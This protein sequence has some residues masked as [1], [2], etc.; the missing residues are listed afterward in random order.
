MQFGTE[1]ALIKGDD[2]RLNS[3]AV[4][5]YYTLLKTNVKISVI[6]CELSL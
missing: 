3:A 1:S 4:A 5:A 6:F 2:V